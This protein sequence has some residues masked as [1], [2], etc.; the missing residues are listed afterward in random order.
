SKRK[1][2]ILS[3]KNT[4]ILEEFYQSIIR[5]PYPNQTSRSALAEKC[6]LTFN[7]ISKWFSNRRNKDK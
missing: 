4:E 3:Q 5:F 6:G 2:Q 7:Q 1:R